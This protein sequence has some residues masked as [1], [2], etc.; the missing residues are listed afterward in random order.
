MDCIGQCQHTNLS[1]GELCGSTDNLE[2]H[3]PF[4]ESKHY[5][6]G[7]RFQQRVL[8]C[9]V[10]HSDAHNGKPSPNAKRVNHLMDDVVYE[11]EQA[12]SYAAW[13]VTHKLYDEV[14]NPILQPKFM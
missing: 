4:R 2:F 3:E 11:I 7:P 1:T 6:L 10:H 9:T 8:L 5:D 13:L 12:G 14:C